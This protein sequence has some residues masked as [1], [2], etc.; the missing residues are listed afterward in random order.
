MMILLVAISGVDIGKAKR[1]ATP[2]DNANFAGKKPASVTKY[3]PQLFVRF[4]NPLL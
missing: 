4:F 2:Q 3:L 1:A